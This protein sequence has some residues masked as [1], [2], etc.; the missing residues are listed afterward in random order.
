MN[1]TEGKLARHSRARQGKQSKQT[2]LRQKEHFA[3]A[4]AGLLPNA[5]HHIPPSQPLFSCG[6]SHPDE[7]SPFRATLHHTVAS[8]DN[9]ERL[10]RRRS[11]PSTHGFKSVDQT[12]SAYNL[13]H[14]KDGSRIPDALSLG[15]LD[16]TAIREKRQK[17]LREHDWAG[18]R[19]QKPIPVR[20]E[21]RISGASRW[22]TRHRSKAGGTRHQI[23]MGY[24]QTKGVNDSITHPHRGQHVYITVGSQEVRLGGGSSVRKSDDYAPID[25]ETCHTYGAASMPGT[26]LT[27]SSTMTDPIEKLRNRRQRA[28][29][30]NSYFSSVS[31]SSRSHHAKDDSGG[32][33]HLKAP[34]PVR[35]L[36]GLPKSLI[37]ESVDYGDDDSMVAGNGK[38]ASPVAA[39][40]TE[41]NEVWRK[42]TALS[43]SNHD[44]QH[45][46]FDE[47]TNRFSHPRISP[48]VSARCH[49]KTPKAI[50][51]YDPM[52]SVAADMSGSLKHTSNDT[53]CQHDSHSGQATSLSSEQ[54]TL[55]HSTNVSRIGQESISYD[56]AKCGPAT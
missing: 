38:F 7:V 8:G 9:P 2:R 17:L 11:S 49:Q 20:F 18:I 45:S 31:E 1:W 19:M 46:T 44:H 37:N 25:P 39:S 51:Q 55:Q 40:R 33:R 22:A 54:S 24:D 13:N 27:S 28:R 34:M 36:T 15:Q 4:R 12:S 21:Q 52:N 47:P 41:D 50:I 16:D 10:K 32:R 35:Y 30:R 29:R 26:S 14:G 56:H 5:S 23:S 3:K 43:Q 42:F 6:A 53:C 48:G